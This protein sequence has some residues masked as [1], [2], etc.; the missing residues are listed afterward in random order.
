MSAG[1]APQPEGMANAVPIP[2]QPKRRRTARAC[3]ECRRKKIKCDGRHPCAH[4]TAFGFECTYNQLSKRRRTPAAQYVERL[5]QRVRRAEQLLRIVCPGASLNDT[6]ASEK[7]R[8]LSSRDFSCAS[9]TETASSGADSVVPSMAQLDVDDDGRWDYHGQSSSL[10]FIRKL[11]DHLGRPAGPEA[12]PADVLSGRS[13]RSLSQPMH[14]LP[15]DFLPE[16]AVAQ[17]YCQYSLDRVAALLPVVHTPT[18]WQQLEQLYAAPTSEQPVDD[19]R[20]RAL[21]YSVM[22]LGHLAGGDE[23]NAVERAFSYFKAAQRSLDI[24]DC[25]D[26]VS[27]QALVFMMVFLQSTAKL[28]E[29][30][31]YLGIALRFAIRIGMHRSHAA[32]FGPVETEM[33]KRVFWMLRQMDISIGAALGVPQTLSDNDVDQEFP[34]EVNDKNI[35]NAGVAPVIDLNM[36]AFNHLTRLSLLLAK[37]VR[38]VYPTKPMAGSG[39]EGYAVRFAVIR[40]LEE[41]LKQ[42]KQGLPPELAADDP[43]EGLMRVQHMLRIAFTHTRLMLYRPFYHFVAARK[44]SVDKRAHVCAATCV[45]LSRTLIHI[46][47]QSEDRGLLHAACWFIVHSNLF[48]ILSLL[49]FASENAEDGRTEAIVYDAYRGLD[50]LRA[51]SQRSPAADRCVIALMPIFDLLPKNLRRKQQA[52]DSRPT[53]A[54]IVTKDNLWCPGPSVEAPE[55]FSTQSQSMPFDS[56]MQPFISIANPGLGNVLGEADLPDIESLEAQFP[57]SFETLDELAMPPSTGVF[58][59]PNMFGLDASSFQ[60]YEGVHWNPD[61]GFT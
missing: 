2:L 42:W 24:V 20:F 40:E 54:L 1:P 9:S 51:M 39:G 26:L 32:D 60:G 7:A 12:D 6:Q 16:K 19:S 5:E 55:V 17:R 35:T 61:F 8:R 30:Y 10:P 49:Y 13:Q 58:M 34:A 18:F 38:N 27:I 4:C 43:P 33:R 28:S 57:P 45:N 47:A 48:A 22:A 31:I 37:I 29:C 21:F 56:T 11:Q 52:K 46:T 41:D 23:T 53:A 14:E 15:K 25:R 44:R 36:T 59:W 50:M 3:D